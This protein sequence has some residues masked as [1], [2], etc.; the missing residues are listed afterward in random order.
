M[1]HYHHRQ[2]GWAMLIIFGVVLAFLV[3][4]ALLDPT[5][6]AGVLVAMVLIVGVALL[7]FGWLT[8]TV[9][10]QQ[11][12]LVLGFGLIRRTAKL[13]EMRACAVVQNPWYYSMGV[14]LIPRGWIYNVSLGRGVEIELLN[15]KLI[16]VGSDD[17][18]GL[19]AAI[20]ARLR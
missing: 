16:R 11:F 15:G 10:D 3:T 17:A 14:H 6:P 2:M 9:N 8:T 18:E 19:C 20:N 5:I 1:P 4:L 13:T 12:R 7:S